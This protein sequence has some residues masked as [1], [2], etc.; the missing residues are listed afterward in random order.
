MNLESIAFHISVLCDLRT[1]IPSPP[2]HASVKC[3]GTAH[4]AQLLTHLKAGFTTRAEDVHTSN[5]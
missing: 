5:W 3:C 2:P 1:L 4:T